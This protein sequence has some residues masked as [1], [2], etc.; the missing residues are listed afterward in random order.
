MNNENDLTMPAPGADYDY[1]ITMASIHQPGVCKDQNKKGH[2]DPDQT[3]ECRDPNHDTSLSKVS[4]QQCVA[5][6]EG[7][8]PL[9]SR[10]IYKAGLSIQLHPGCH[11]AWQDVDGKDSLCNCRALPR[12][13]ICHMRNIRTFK[14]KATEIDA[15][16][17]AKR[18]ARCKEELDQSEAVFIYTH[19]GNRY[20]VQGN[21]P[22]DWQQEAYTPNQAPPRRRTAP[23]TKT[24]PPTKRKVQKRPK[25]LEVHDGYDI[26][27]LDKILYDDICADGSMRFRCSWVGYPSEDDR[28]WE[29]KESFQDN[30]R[31]LSEWFNKTNTPSPRLPDIER[32]I[33]AGPVGGYIVRRSG[34]AANKPEWC[35]VEMVNMEHI[36]AF[37]G[38]EDD[39]EDDEMD[40]DAQFATVA[41]VQP[42]VSSG[43]V[44]Q[45]VNALSADEN[46]METSADDQDLVSSRQQMGMKDNHES[47][48]SLVDDLRQQ[49]NTLQ[50]TNADLRRQK[51][52]DNETIRTMQ[53]RLVNA[54]IVNVHQLQQIE[55]DVVRRVGFEQR[56]DA[57]ED[58]NT[59]LREVMA[60]L[61]ASQAEVWLGT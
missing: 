12:C 55:Q 41:A 18:C 32:I 19:N 43:K 2:A 40:V 44:R 51:V 34:Q 59:Q 56:H 21:E 1:E 33:S 61:E 37:E 60:R 8:C 38:V 52:T 17:A 3:H 11:A 48:S 9:Q 13:G 26:F 25:P 22:A 5:R 24:P 42:A 53:A 30:P 49:I 58:E 14:D 35:P 29:P 36:Q 6:A 31:L 10:E 46:Q 23:K 45:S 16:G 28:T 20:A 15:E 50:S 4:C 7:Y 57:L 39:P 47:E 54:G 27:E